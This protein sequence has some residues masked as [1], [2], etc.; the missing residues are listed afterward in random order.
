M[1]KKTVLE[2]GLR[3]VSHDMNQR[4]SV[5]IGLWIG[6]GGRYEVDRIKGAAHFLEHIVFKGSKKYSCEQMFRI[7]SRQGLYEE[8]L[9]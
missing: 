1:Y 3:I 8:D 6:A 2:N 4:D 7:Y 9:N 5:A